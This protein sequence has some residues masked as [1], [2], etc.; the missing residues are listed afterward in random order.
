M[1]HFYRAVIQ[2]IL[3]E[4]EQSVVGSRNEVDNLFPS[5]KNMRGDDEW[6]SGDKPSSKIT[7]SFGKQ[8]V[9]RAISVCP[10]DSYIWDSYETIES[11]KGNHEQVSNLKWKRLKLKN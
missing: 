3:Q 10:A 7:V 8:V 1:E 5:K 4:C 9:E 6:P 11:W 2:L